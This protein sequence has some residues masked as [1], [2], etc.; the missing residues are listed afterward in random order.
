MPKLLI[1]G[2]GSVIM[3]DDGV[4]VKVVNEL[5]KLAPK[6]VDILDGGT[7]GLSLLPHIKN[8]KEIIIIDALRGGGKQPGTIYRLG[9]SELQKP[10]F[11]VFSLHDISLEHVLALGKELFKEEFPN[12]ITIYGVETS[13]VKLSDKL[14]EPVKKAV[15]KLVNLLKSRI[16]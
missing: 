4:G 16:T 3:G 2:L 1:I 8:R 6:N 13:V 5:K 7:S 15:P 12:N 14:S 11:K 10:E 9:E